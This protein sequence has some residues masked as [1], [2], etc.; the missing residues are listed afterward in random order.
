M[1]HLR[2]FSHVLSVLSVP[3]ALAAVTVPATEAVGTNY[4]TGFIRWRADNGGFGGWQRSGVSLASNGTARLDPATASS[5]HDPYP[6]GSYNGGN[7]YNGGAFLVGE[8]VSPVM[9]TSFGF[10]EAIASWNVETPTGTWIETQIQA[11][12]GDRWT[13]WYNLGV[14]AADYSTIRRH[15]VRGQGDKDGFVAIDT[16]ILTDKQAPATAFQLKLRLFRAADATRVTPTV[17][18]ISLAVSTAPSEARSRPPG[19]PA[20]W[21]R[22]LA[23]PQRC[24]MVYPDRCDVRSKPTS[25]RMA[26][27]SSARRAADCRPRVRGALEGVFD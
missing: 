22:T 7:F 27:G 16:L 26:V 23:V 4:Q 21:T 13:K 1:R 11:R 25:P 15:A 6:A 2:I 9:P 24:Q 20:R 3:L 14:W 12:V 8:M 19:D 18:N 10:L 17:R 5:G